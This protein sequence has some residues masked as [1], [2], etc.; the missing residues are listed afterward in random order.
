MEIFWFFSQQYSAKSG[1]NDKVSAICAFQLTYIVQSD[2]DI[3]ARGAQNS[4]ELATASSL[5]GIFQ[6]MYLD[7]STPAFLHG[8]ISVSFTSA[9]FVASILRISASLSSSVKVLCLWL[10][11]GGYLV[12]DPTYVTEAKRDL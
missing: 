5:I 12:L 2:V 10:I 6:Q 4:I 8:P 7:L 1:T 9:A 3:L 11:L